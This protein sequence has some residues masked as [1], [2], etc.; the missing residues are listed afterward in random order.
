MSTRSTSTGH[1]PEVA[2]LQASLAHTRRAFLAAVEP[3]RPRLHRFCSAMTRSPLDGEDMVQEVLA[4]A[5]FRLSGLHDVRRMEAWLFRI[6]HNKCVD[7]LRKRRELPM[8]D[9][10]L[11]A[12]PQADP[13]ESAE[14]VS[15]AM[16]VL[17]ADLPPRERASVI[18]KDV[19]DCSLQDIAEV[20]HS[21]VGGVKAALHRGRGKLKRGRRRDSAAADKPLRREL[22]PAERELLQAYVERFN[23]RDWEAVKALVRQDIRVDV[24]GIAGGRSQAFMQERYFRNYERLGD[25]WRLGLARVAGEPVVVC[26]RRRGD[27]WVPQSALRVEITEGKIAQIRDYHHVSYLLD[28]TPPSDAL[29]I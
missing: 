18:L 10:E 25:S 21:S 27:D 14:A 20:V 26:Y 28:G 8:N 7:F 1:E 4:Q 23:Q 29:P 19:L 3:M 11:P 9:D 24:V 6:A 16:A 22:A 17:V 5:F 15:Q 12:E 13:I 2:E